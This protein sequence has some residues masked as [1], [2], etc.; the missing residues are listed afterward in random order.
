MFF[1]VGQVFSNVAYF[2]VSSYVDRCHN[3]WKAELAN[4]NFSMYDIVF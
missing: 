3:C 4:C 1:T 2:F